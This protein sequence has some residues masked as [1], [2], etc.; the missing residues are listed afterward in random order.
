MLCYVIFRIAFSRRCTI[1]PS[2]VCST[3]ELFASA[4][5]IDAASV[6]SLPSTALSAVVQCLLKALFSWRAQVD[7]NLFVS[8]M[9]KATVKTSPGEWSEWDCTWATVQGTATQML[10]QDGTQCPGLW[11]KKSQL[12]RSKR[13][14]DLKVQKCPA[15]NSNC[16]LR[17]IEINGPHFAGMCRLLKLFF[18]YYLDITVFEF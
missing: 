6:G 12:H 2:C 14:D 9:L 8:V 10:I 7:T 16:V 13:F 11:L 4:N 15:F 3:P 1:K 5:A 17:P 18:L